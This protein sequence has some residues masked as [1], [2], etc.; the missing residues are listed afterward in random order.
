VAQRLSSRRHVALSVYFPQVVYRLAFGLRRV[1]C[2]ECLAGSYKMKLG[3][4]I[5]FI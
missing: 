4:A 3:K 1:A 5:S 2:G